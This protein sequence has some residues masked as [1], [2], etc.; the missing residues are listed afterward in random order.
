MLIVVII[1]VYSQ[2]ARALD[3]VGAAVDTAVRGANA[4]GIAA[5]AERSVVARGVVRAGRARRAVG[6]G[7]RR[8]APAPRRALAHDH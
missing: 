6:G 7:R 5:K 3:P 4:A 8:A 1:I 2:T